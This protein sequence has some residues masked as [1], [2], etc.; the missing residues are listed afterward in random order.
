[1]KIA[2][3]SQTQKSLTGHAGHCRK[4]WV[5]EL[6]NNEIIDKKFLELSPEQSFHNSSPDDPHPLDEV[7]VLISGGM[8][9]NL[10]HR[11][12]KRGIQ[13]VI[14]KETDLDKAVNAYLD[15]SLVSEEAECH[16]HEH[17]HEHGHDHQHDHECQ[18]NQ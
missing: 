10:L 16:E 6:N 1:M 17:E 18:C 13:A 2:L 5:Y 14:T 3:S 4:F 12:E 8:G 15:G 9:K 11:L 7:Q